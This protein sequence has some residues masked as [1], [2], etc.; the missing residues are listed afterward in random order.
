MNIINEQVDEYIR[1]L[2][3]PLNDNLK[4]LR[5]DAEEKNIPIILPDTETLLL[6]LIKLKKPKEILEIGTAIGYSASCFAISDEECKITT[7]ETDKDLCQVAKS[8]ILDL[9]LKER[10]TVINGKGQEIIPTLTKSYDLV[11]IDAAKSHY[12]AFWDEAIKICSE[13]AMIVCDNVLMR[14]TTVSDEY[15]PYRKHRTSIRRMREFLN[16]IS[17]LEN[18]T[19]SLLPIGDGISISILKG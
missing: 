6:S 11:F 18:T 7:V 8:N 17:N 5:E 19:F 4:K 1:H 15:D 10:I 16:Y 2:Y 12:R 9:G 3:Q 14:G 13:N